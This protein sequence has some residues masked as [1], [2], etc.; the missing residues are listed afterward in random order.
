MA[1]RVRD[2]TGEEEQKI[3][4]WA[5]S[6]TEPA[7]LV[8]RA[9]MIALSREGLKVPAIARQVGVSEANVRRWIRRFN[10]AGVEGL[11]DLPRPGSPPTYSPEQVGEVVVAALTKPE[12]LGLPFACWTLDRLEAYLNEQ[13]GIPIKRSRI[14]EILLSEGLRWRQ[15]E[16]W[17][18][19]RMDPEFVEKRGRLNGCT[20]SLPTARS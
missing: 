5:R 10:D 20:R 19:E 11:E 2:L 16:T 1:L 9:Q 15:Q 4:R 18:G 13:K 6:R 17:F 12:E 3:Q 8:E 14:D 7:R